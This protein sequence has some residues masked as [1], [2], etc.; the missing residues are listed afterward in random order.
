MFGGARRTQRCVQ[1]SKVNFVF[2]N[3]YSGTAQ[4]NERLNRSGVIIVFILSSQ[5]IIALHS[6]KLVF[7]LEKRR[8]TRDHFAVACE[9]AARIRPE[10][11]VLRISGRIR[12][13]F[14]LR[15]NSQRIWRIQIEFAANLHP[16]LVQHRQARGI[17]APAPRRLAAGAHPGLLYVGGPLAAG[18]PATHG[19]RPQQEAGTGVGQPPRTGVEPRPGGASTGRVAGRRH[20][21]H[22]HPGPPRGANHARPPGGYPGGGPTGTAEPA[23]G[24]LHV[25]PGGRAHC[26]LRP[27]APAGARSRGPRGR[28]YPHD[29]QGATGERTPCPPVPGQA[30]GQRPGGE[31]GGV[32][33]SGAPPAT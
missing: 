1:N 27:R 14:A 31:A 30:E 19:Q 5:K 2:E 26:R 9:F 22:G 23:G 13:E 12:S 32:A 18:S 24:G 20:Q 10:F 3:G 4:E 25:Q 15:T 28:L 7:H 6:S 21:S 29:R 11:A 16:Y 8:C 17:P 33:G